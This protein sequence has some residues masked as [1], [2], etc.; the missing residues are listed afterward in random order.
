MSAIQAIVD[1]LRDAGKVVKEL[2]GDRY[3]AQCP[4]HDDTN[5]SLSIGPRKD[6]AGAV[7]C[8]HAGCEYTEVLTAIGLGV[9]DLFNDPKVRRAMSPRQSHRYHN[10]A[11][12]ERWPK[13]GGG[14][15]MRWSNGN[16]RG[17][18]YGADKIS[19]DCPLVFIN[20]SEASADLING[21][22]AVGVATGGVSAAKHCD[23]SA[24][25]GMDVVPIV[26]RD[27]SGLQWAH[28]VHAAWPASPRRPRG[29]GRR[30]T[31]P[32]ATCV[33][34]SRQSWHW[35]NWRSS[36]HSRPATTVRKAASQR[37]R[38][39]PTRRASST[40]TQACWCST[41]PRR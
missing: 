32:P 31:S 38:T 12:K 24:L 3:S 9:S 19:P 10:G 41:S 36:T 37:S 15:G 33:T 28:H 35:S 4:A 29:S 26:D 34:T 2:G 1:A 13:S 6:G 20:E 18:L 39:S 25:E 27:P 40:L 8:C 14:K 30:W 22:G 5:P 7:V 23:Y 11:T 17:L 21:L 16:G